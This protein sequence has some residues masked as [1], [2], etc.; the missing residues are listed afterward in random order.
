MS[1]GRKTKGER[2]SSG[3]ENSDSAMDETPDSLQNDLSSM[4][5]QPSLL[6]ANSTAA[7]AEERVEENTLSEPNEA[8]SK[9]NQEGEETEKKTKKGQT[10]KTS[11]ADTPT[12]HPA[13]EDTTSMTSQSSSGKGT[14]TTKDQTNI[15]NSKNK[16]DTETT[17]QPR[18]DQNANVAPNVNKATQS[19]QK[20]K[21][22][23]EQKQEEKPKQNVAPEKQMVQQSTSGQ[24]ST[25]ANAS[26][27]DKRNKPGNN[28]D[29]NTTADSP[30]KR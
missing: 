9:P 24:N 21:G 29:S 22:Q 27:G 2:D 13:I 14:N 12:E 3:S 17:K 18:L 11:P 26:P 5:S 19:K 6:S 20:G 28:D 15:I 25:L 8:T 1:H 16:K 30:P 10:L 4:E 23:Q 7:A